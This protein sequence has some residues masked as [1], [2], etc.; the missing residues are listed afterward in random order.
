MLHC[1]C[2]VLEI[3]VDTACT[4]TPLLGNPKE[5]S[6][7][8]QCSQIEWSIAQVNLVMLVE[9]LYLLSY[10]PQHPRTRIGSAPLSFALKHI[11]GGPAL[12]GTPAQVTQKV[13]WHYS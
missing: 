13:E 3:S 5:V 12:I 2:D 7:A 8:E 4:S 11:C 6:T 10:A 9:Q 1:T